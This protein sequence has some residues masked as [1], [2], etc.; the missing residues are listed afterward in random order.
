[1]NPGFRVQ[2]PFRPARGMYSDR[3]WNDG[4]SLMVDQY[5]PH[6]DMT[7]SSWEITPGQ[8]FRHHPNLY[9]RIPT[10]ND[11]YYRIPKSAMSEYRNYSV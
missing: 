2:S 7:D 1:M 3:L 11:P 8:L 4:R 9:Q 6:R 5:G 10:W